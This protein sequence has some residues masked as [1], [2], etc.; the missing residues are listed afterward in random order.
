M[1]EG[2]RAFVTGRGTGIGRACALALA[3]EGCSV[4]VA[5]R[6]ERT[7]DE[8][9]TTARYARGAMPWLGIIYLTNPGKGS[10]VSAWKNANSALG[11][12]TSGSR[13]RSLRPTS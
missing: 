2:K 3:A 7:Q 13:T 9:V 5:G 6:T 12:S 10:R 11:T 1:F 8:T 4:T